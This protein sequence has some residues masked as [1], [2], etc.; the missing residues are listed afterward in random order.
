MG[1]LFD[2]ARSKDPEAVEKLLR[3][4]RGM[5]RGVCRGGGPPG[6]LDLDW[7][8]VA[9]E[10]YRR[11]LEVGF[12]SYRARGSER[13]Y[14]YSVVKATVIQ[15]SR[16]AQRRQKREEA[17]AAAPA[18]AAEDVASRLSARRILDELD[19][20]CRDLIERLFLHDQTYND[21]ARELG[22]VE[23][24]VRSKLSRCLR[25]AR[26]IAEKGGRS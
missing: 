16:S 17:V 10:A 4:V 25:R 11:L 21:A 14:V 1:D 3:M 20:A 7:E 23:S 26:Q 9:Q 2:A 18:V 22:M 8:D 24:S 13:S 19:E 5:A 12:T 15:L 6:A